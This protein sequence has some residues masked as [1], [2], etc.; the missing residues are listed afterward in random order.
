MNSGSPPRQVPTLTE[1][2][3]EDLVAEQT[4]VMSGD[5]EDDAGVAPEVQDAQRDE[6]V[7]VAADALSLDRTAEQQLVERVLADVQRQIDPMLEQRLREM[8]A[9]MLAHWSEALIEDSRERLSSLL[10]DVVAQAVARE[11]ERQRRR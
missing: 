3:D 1:V 7:D 4:R 10:R 2:V 9:P 6:P 11:F 8:L 5:V